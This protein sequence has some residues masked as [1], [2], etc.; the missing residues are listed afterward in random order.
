MSYR[1]SHIYGKHNT[2]SLSDFLVKTPKQRLLLKLTS[3]SNKISQTSKT[4]RLLS[5]LYL[6]ANNGTL[7]L[8]QVYHRP[9][10]AERTTATYLRQRG[11]KHHKLSLQRSL[12]KNATVLGICTTHTTCAIFENVKLFEYSR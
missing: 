7:F 2:N 1:A 12:S 4:F 9:T 8:S 10:C 5:H 3:D 6:G 11:K